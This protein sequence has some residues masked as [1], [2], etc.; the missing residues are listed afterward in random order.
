[1]YQPENHS[2]KFT[3]LLS[4]IEQGNIKIPQFQR[5]FVWRKEQSAKLMDSIIKGYPIGT[6]ILWKTKEKLRSIRNIGGVDLPDT[7]EGD[8]IQY[9]LDG[10]Q[11][12][13]S[14]YASLKGIRINRE[15][16]S[17][18]FSEIYIDLLAN[19]DEDEYIVITDT[20]DKEEGSIIKLTE[21]LNGGLALA[22]KYDQKHHDKIDEY[23]KRIAT[24]DF[25][26][27]LIKNS[28]IDVA[29]EIFTRINIGGKK[30][31]VF[32]I[33]VAKTYDAERNF[34]LS[35][36]YDKLIASLS[37]VDYET[38]SDATVLQAVSICL[39][40]ECSKKH[41]LKLD[42]QQFV[43]IWDD[44]IDAIERTVD[45]FKGYYRIPVSRLLPY[46]ALVVPFAY[47]FYNHKDKPMGEQQMY[48]QDYFW[49]AV[50]TERFSSGVETKLAQDIKKIDLIL[51]DIKPS[52]DQ[53]VDIRPSAII[54]NGWFSAG[55]SYVKGLL[56]ILTYKIPLS[57]NDNSIVQINNNWL[58]QANSKNYHH[59]F[60]RAY[61][62]RQGE[63]EFRINHILNI[64]IVDDF[65]NKRQIKAN[66]P[67]NYMKKFKDI[68][69]SLEN[70]M[71][72]HLIN[73]LGDFGIWDNDYDKF[74]KMRAKAFSNELEKRIIIDKMDIRD[75]D[76]NNDKDFINK[77]IE[78]EINYKSNNLKQLEKE[79][80]KDMKNIY[81]QA[82]K[83]CGYRP[84]RFLQMLSELGGV[85]TAKKLINKPGGTE[86]FAKLWE[87]GSLDLT[88]E[89]LVI[90]EKYR[91]LFTPEEIENCIRIL[92]NYNYF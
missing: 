83:D 1:M 42:K 27:I 51:K 5:D 11:R 66:P 85:E 12:M 9:V 75:S 86:G 90:N 55:R 45:Y 76:D 38:I 19:E 18:D 58:K 41:I 59:F 52:Y 54:Q 73:N 6:F 77:G 68:N 10:Q 14:L 36:Q 79:F 23:Y 2:Y 4:D 24:Y 37:Q 15:T 17:E 33:M 60:P 35:E 78:E 32:E 87:A 20:S 3:A 25:P 92:K 47:Y 34:D 91:E 56:N 46:N 65:L 40:K 81:V 39:V 69:P 30:L 48:L 26:A 71:T 49:R 7:P 80:F 21:L 82:D 43:D 88:V 22:R 63:D 29:T 72:T 74:F 13:T 31:S 53:G 84:T 57:F 70:T 16:S 61:L 28:S 8:F 50:L 89:A 67:A 62:K 64:T 44:V